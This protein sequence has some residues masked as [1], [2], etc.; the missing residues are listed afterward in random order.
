MGAL[1]RARDLLGALEHAKPAANGEKDDD[2]QA[3]GGEIE[4]GK[5]QRDD[6]DDGAESDAD[7][8]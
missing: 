3:E 2:I 4:L 1:R 6:Q 8:R 5:R 7:K